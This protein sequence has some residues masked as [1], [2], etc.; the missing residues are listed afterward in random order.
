MIYTYDSLD[1][2]IIANEVITTGLADG[3][4]CTIGQNEESFS[5]QVGIQG[6]V[7]FSET[8]DKTGFATV[9]LKATS[10]A[11]QQYEELSRLKGETALFPFWVIDANT[12]GLTSGGTKCRV[13]KSAEKSYSN[14]EGTREYE[15]EIADYTSK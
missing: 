3:D 7:T 12:N 5:K 8:N 2:T 1:V 4:A 11:V 9:T 14:E 10:P 13:K 15:I 6:D